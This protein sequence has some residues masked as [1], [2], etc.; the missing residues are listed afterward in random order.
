MADTRKARLASHFSSWAK[1][2][3]PAVHDSSRDN[4]PSSCEPSRKRKRDC[5]LPCDRA[6]RAVNSLDKRVFLSADE[7]ER[8]LNQI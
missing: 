3:K 5:E 6:L 4:I 2:S 8:R 1:I 7:I